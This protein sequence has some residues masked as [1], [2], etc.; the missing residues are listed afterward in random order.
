M[1]CLAIAGHGLFAFLAIKDPRR[2]I[3]SGKLTNHLIAAMWA[4]W[5]RRKLA[6]CVFTLGI[7]IVISHSSHDI[8]GHG[9]IQTFFPSPHHTKTGPPAC[10]RCLAAH[11]HTSVPKLPRRYAAGCRR[12]KGGWTC[13]ESAYGWADCAGSCG[14]A[15][16]VELI[17]GISSTASFA[18][19]RM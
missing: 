9:R 2:R 7:Y 4:Q 19:S 1:P 10:H 13:S 18:L 15:G 12:R 3:I 16:A 6:H 5:G 17:S 11:A 8:M 14:M